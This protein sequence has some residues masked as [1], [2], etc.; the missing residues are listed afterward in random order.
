MQTVEKIYKQG[1]KNKDFGKK[2]RD[3][4]KI[5][6][7]KKQWKQIY[8]EKYIY[9]YSWKKHRDGGKKN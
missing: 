7:A 2:N 1:G 4:W 8:S 3:I 6:M 9:K 5:N